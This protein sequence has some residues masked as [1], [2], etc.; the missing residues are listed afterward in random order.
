MAVARPIRPS[1]AIAT[2]VV[3]VAA[4]I[5][6]VAC[7][8]DATS[9][10]ADAIASDGGSAA[11][12][13]E[14]ARSFGLTIRPAVT[15]GVPLRVVDAGRGT[16]VAGALVV[17]VDECEFNYSDVQEGTRISDTRAL[18]RTLGRAYAT[19][20]DGRV[21]V[22][23]PA[24]PTSVFVWH[25]DA[26]GRT[27]LEVHDRDEHEVTLAPRALAVEVVDASARPQANVPIQLA[28]CSLEPDSP[29][30]TVA[31]TDRDGRA[32]I[33]A[34]EL[35]RA[36]HRSCG[37]RDLVMV[38]DLVRGAAFQAVDARSLE[39]V[40]FVLPECGA[41]E[42]ELQDALGRPLSK[43]AAVGRR[44]VLLATSSVDE[45]PRGLA[46]KRADWFDLER[47]CIRRLIEG[48]KCRFD[49]VEVG[50]I[51]RFDLDILTDLLGG[52]ER[53]RDSFH[54]VG[55]DVNDNGSVRGPSR[56]GE[57]VRLT[58]RADSFGA[59][60]EDDVDGEGGSEEERLPRSPA[61]S[62]AETPSPAVDDVAEEADDSSSIDV[63][64][65]VDFPIEPCTLSARLDESRNPL[66]SDSCPWIDVN[67]RAT[68]RD[69]TPGDDHWVEITLRSLGWGQDE[70]SLF[71]LHG[72]NVAPRQRLR[73]P[74]LLAIDLRGRLRRHDVTIVDES[75][76]PLSGPVLV[77]GAPH[78]AGIP[79]WFSDGTLTFLTLADRSPEVVVAAEG[80]RPAPLDLSAARQ[81]VVLKRG[82]PIRLAL[83]PGFTLPAKP[84]ERLFVG[85]SELPHGMDDDGEEL[86]SVEWR[87]NATP[88]FDLAEPGEW[89]VRFLVAD[90]RDDSNDPP[91]RER[92]SLAS[93]IV[94]ADRTEETLV[95]VAPD[96][97]CWDRFVRGDDGRE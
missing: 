83:A 24:S 31:T 11:S 97:D 8:S 14:L 94:V 25:G 70:V 96:R 89:Q 7:H 48:S 86:R 52:T 18:L 40:R 50:T 37:R 85:V 62:S 69:V 27:T 45:R 44:L 73:D 28:N 92:P 49:H 13:E 65:L 54:A 59:P 77:R 22:A 19:A 79:R 29:G 16:P 26:F 46:R 51:L 38:G 80:F 91:C 90:A 3:A 67:G 71:E 66:D 53:S 17:T 72:V 20:P 5:L 81:R 57:V 15:D 78:D 64:V 76:R 41:V 4:S 39:P 61:E 88:R 1:I 87:P 60:H 43:T 9:P 32:S 35:E 6:G 34:L 63:A 12:A 58:L 33:P 10:R 30:L 36:V 56:S 95:E 75:G 47:R 42:I 23:R 68:M 84:R 21:S 93:T 74:R 55:A 82:I 2:A